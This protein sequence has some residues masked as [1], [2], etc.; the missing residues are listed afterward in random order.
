MS[1][2]LAFEL[3]ALVSRLDRAADRLLQAEM[4]IAYR[5][6]LVLFMVD[7]LGA[8]T[9]RALA[10]RLDVS[11]PSVSRMTGLLAEAGLLEVAAAPEGGHRRRLAL[12][13]DG[14]QLVDRCR[15]LLS[16]RLGEVVE[17]SG[18]PAEEYLAH[19]QRLSALL[20]DGGPGA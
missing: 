14:K 19:T 5:R 1:G 17:R 9:Q 7:E 16:R 13:P 8:T 11:D 2:A 12:T 4:G 18:V 6:F 10:R 15:D 20:D 3:H